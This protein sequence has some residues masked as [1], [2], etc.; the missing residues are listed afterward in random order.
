MA[1]NMEPKAQAMLA[2]WRLI[3]EY[4]PPGEQISRPEG[5]RGPES[6]GGRGRGLRVATTMFVTMFLRA[7]SAVFALGWCS[8]G[9]S[10][11]LSTPWRWGSRDALPRPQT[12]GPFRTAPAGVN[13][14]IIWHPRGNH[15]A[16]YHFTHSIPPRRHPPNTSVRA[17]R[18]CEP[19]LGVFWS[20]VES[21]GQCIAGF[22]L[23]RLSLGA[24]RVWVQSR[25]SAD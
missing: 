24:S 6:L 20:C 15:T 4:A 1:R 25:C 12:A 7:I 9:P 3:L 17:H 5:R 16:E 2:V 11:D 22:F 23:T 10:R 21:A 8:A 18:R 19:Q 13:G 14:H